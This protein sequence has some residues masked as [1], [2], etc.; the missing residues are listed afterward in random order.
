MLDKK[1]ILE[2]WKLAVVL[3]PVLN[4]AKRDCRE[5]ISMLAAERLYNNYFTLIIKT[6]KLYKLSL[7]LML[8]CLFVSIHTIYRPVNNRFTLFKIVN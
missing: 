6:F 2:K 5:R 1:T 7:L 4:N 3:V 8:T